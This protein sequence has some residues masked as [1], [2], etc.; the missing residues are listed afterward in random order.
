MDE[1]IIIQSTHY[2]VKKFFI[3]MV[4]TGVVL[5]VLFTI[6]MIST[7]VEDY[8]YSYG[9]NHEHE[10]WCYK[11]EYRDEYYD[12]EWD[13]NLQEYKMDCPQVVYGNAV[14]Y[15]FGTYFG[16]CIL[17]TLLIV[18]FF[19]LVGGIIYRGLRSYEMTVTDKRIFGKVAW[20]KRVDLPVDSVSAVS[21]SSMKGLAVATSSGRIAFK[22]IKNRDEIHSAVSQLIIDRQ[23]QVKT[24]A[25]VVKQETVTS[26]ADELKKYKELLDSGIITQEE[27]DAKKKQLLGL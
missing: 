16:G 13:G 15:A 23:N 1:K 8:N 27:F 19:T 20:G 6:F 26:N 10:S 9:A 3:A 18:G 24:A 22:L 7:G 4:I 21:T 17:M 11:W 14:G 5:S 12:D 2:N 25:P